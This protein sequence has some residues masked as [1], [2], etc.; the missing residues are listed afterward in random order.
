MVI[1]LTLLTWAA[2]VMAV[3]HIGIQPR[4]GPDPSTVYIENISYGGNGCPDGTVNVVLDP[5]GETSV[6]PRL[7]PF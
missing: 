3:P 2:A 6:K 4:A 7:S 1:L 5:S